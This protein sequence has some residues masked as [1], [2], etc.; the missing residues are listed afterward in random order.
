MFSKTRTSPYKSLP[1]SEQITDPAKISRLLKGFTK[2]YTP[3]T[4]RVPGQKE[5]YTSCIV[6]IDK[7]HVL[8]DEL[9]PNSGHELLVAEGA[10][11]VTGMLDGVAIQFFTTLKRVDDKGKMLTYHMKLPTLLEYRQRRQNFRVR[12]PM[13]RKLP[14]TIV[15]KNGK[16]VK[17][18]LHDLSHGGAGMLFLAD[19]T[20][21][22]SGKQ[23]E[24][25][26]ELPDGSFIYCTAELR[27]SKNIPSRNTKFIGIQFVGLLPL[28][29]RL[30]GRCIN[31][32]ERDYIR[33]R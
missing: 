16:M 26:I 30:I 21:M 10:L 33:K 9:L 18:E 17:G 29:S 27:F 4:A 28:Q 11:Q 24:C 12:I 22:E 31:E 1:D 14:V 19:K 13:T 23:H 6:D 3:L 25:T 20:I 5:A 7:K 32:L 2:R 8:L 15:N